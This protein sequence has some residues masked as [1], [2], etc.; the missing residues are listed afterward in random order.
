M[1]VQCDKHESGGYY[2]TRALQVQAFVVV[3]MCFPRYDVHWTH[4]VL[5]VV[6][7]NP[8]CVDPSILNAYCIVQVVASLCCSQTERTKS[9]QSWPKMPQIND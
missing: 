7:S 4:S 9:V 1:T 3:W 5:R 6:G 2:L 8:T